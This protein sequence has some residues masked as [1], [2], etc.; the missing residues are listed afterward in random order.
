MGPLRYD[1][2]HAVQLPIQDLIAYTVIGIL[3]VIG[4]LVCRR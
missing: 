2:I 3:L 1:Y 4:F